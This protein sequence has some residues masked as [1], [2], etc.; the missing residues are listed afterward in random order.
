MAECVSDS[1][2]HLK[3]KVIASPASAIPSDEGP[4]RKHNIWTGNQDILQKWS[5]PLLKSPKIKKMAD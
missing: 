5:T 1:A 2:S 4:A 3:S